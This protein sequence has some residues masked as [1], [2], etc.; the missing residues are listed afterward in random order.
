MA[1]TLYTGAFA[2][3]YEIPR[4]FGF[5]ERI[6]RTMAIEVGMQNSGLGSAGRETFHAL[7]S[8]PLRHLGDRTVSS[9]VSSGLW[10][11]MEKLAIETETLLSPTMS[12]AS[13]SC[14]N[15]GKPARAVPPRL[16]GEEL[17]AL[18]AQL[19]RLGGD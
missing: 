19:G 14:P 7:H 8:H 3:G 15:A 2:L 18:H 16:A 10:R 11:R 1:V 5:E 4:V 9:E 13:C 17:N 12:D 6:R